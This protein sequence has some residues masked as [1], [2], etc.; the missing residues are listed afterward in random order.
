[1][2]SSLV[3]AT[4]K[5]RSLQVIGRSCDSKTAEDTERK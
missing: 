4:L 2:S 1:L 5:R 3:A